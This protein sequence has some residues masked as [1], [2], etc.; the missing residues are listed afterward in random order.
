V[1]PAV[2]EEI[3]NRGIML[4]AYENRGTVKALVITGLFFGIFHFDIT[5]FLGPAVLGAMLGFYAIRT[6]SIFAA[7]LG[8]FLNNTIA[9]IWSYIYRNEPSTEY[10]QVATPELLYSVL[11]GVV[12]TLI[13]IY[14]LKVLYRITGETAEYKPA[15]TGTRADVRS[16]LTHYPV[17]V[18]LSIYAVI[19]LLYLLMIIFYSANN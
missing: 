4:R 1:L 10:I 2:C 9:E 7:M 16:I 3:L 12:C 15:L 17:V 8:H 6:N 18:T 5:N 14:L 13:V 11:I 19:T